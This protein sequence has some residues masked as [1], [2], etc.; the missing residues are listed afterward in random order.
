M[1]R[2]LKEV[3]TTPE[4]PLAVNT[5]PQQPQTFPT[6]RPIPPSSNQAGQEFSKSPE[7][8]GPVLSDEDMLVEDTLEDLGRRSTDTTEDLELT[9]KVGQ[10]RDSS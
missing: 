1:F 5:S 7:E 10:S 2:L 6:R 3:L 8:D 4:R 9:A